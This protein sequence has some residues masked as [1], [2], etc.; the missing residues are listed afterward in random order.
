MRKNDAPLD[1][2][3]TKAIEQTKDNPIFYVQYANARI[4]SIFK[5]AKSLNIP[6]RD[7]D[8]S[9]SDLNKLSTENEISIIR[10]LSEWP[11][12]IFFSVSRYEPHRIAF[13]LNELAQL[14]HS[15]QSLGKI[16]HSMKFLVEEDMQLT[17]ARIALIRSIQIIITSG[18]EIL[19]VKPIDEML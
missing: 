5:R 18:L 19:G 17:S 7:K 16:D 2:D 6:V 10:K 9:T 4:C 8:L 15:L 11:N 3:F 13:Y 1:F 12:V 14:F